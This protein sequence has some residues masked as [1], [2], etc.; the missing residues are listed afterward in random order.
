MTCEYRFWHHRGM[1]DDDIDRVLDEVIRRSQPDSARKMA[2]VR[3]RSKSNAK[4]AARI[5]Q[6]RK[7]RAEAEER[8]KA[9]RKLER[10]IV[11]QPLA[12][13]ILPPGIALQLSAAD[14][15]T[16][17][18]ILTK[19]GKRGPAAVVSREEILTN[20]AK[21]LGSLGGKKGG[22]KGG[23]ARMEALTAEQRSEL[24]RKAAAARWKAA[25]K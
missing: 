5:K 16:L 10:T 21:Y 22:S 8:K 6:M 23:K 19:A 3:K 12:S 14:A 15:E 2:E 24:G 20:A 18:K 13:Q 4:D 1:T 17:N 25:E 9:R 7:R 11:K